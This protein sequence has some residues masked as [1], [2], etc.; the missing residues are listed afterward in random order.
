MTSTSATGHREGYVPFPEAAAQEYRAAGYWAGRT[1]G[2]LLRDTA[3][4]Q[5]QR[6]AVLSDA[7]AQT[8]AELDA[9]A[10]RMAH[11]LLAL[12]INPGDRV[13]VQLP[14]I[15]EFATALF[16]VLRAGIIPSAPCP[17][18]AASRSSTCPRCPKRSPTH[19]RPARRLR[20]PR[21][22]RDRAPSGA[23]SAPRAGRR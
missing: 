12:G 7:G 5:P 15:P 14:N 19:P 10:D 13:I 9:A 8:Y 17:H 3:R 23:E 22:G 18:T 6:P 16:G 1:L 21:A 20:L 4:S 2:D 11:G